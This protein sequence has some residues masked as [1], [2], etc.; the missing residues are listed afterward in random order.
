M[1]A[2]NICIYANLR[3]SD[4]PAATALNSKLRLTYKQCALFQIC[5]SCWLLSQSSTIFILILFPFFFYFWSASH[6]RMFAE[7]RV[8]LV[9]Y[10]QLWNAS[11]CWQFYKRIFTILF[12]NM[13]NC[14]EFHM[15]QKTSVEL[16]NC[17]I[18]MEF[19]YRWDSFCMHW[20]FQA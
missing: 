19:V 15:K 16:Q 5:R 3:A 20:G 8:A 13:K 11:L 10:F 18:L 12:G 7:F 2:P 14:N 1:N 4:F 9:W 6:E 17:S